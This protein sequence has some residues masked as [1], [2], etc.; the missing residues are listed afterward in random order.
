MNEESQAC[1]VLRLGLSHK[2]IMDA[3][4]LC[5]GLAFFFMVFMDVCARAFFFRLTFRQI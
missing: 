5:N 2:F 4:I 3:G 1:A